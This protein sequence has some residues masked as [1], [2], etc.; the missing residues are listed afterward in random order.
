MRWI[1]SRSQLVKL[2]ISAVTDLLMIM[3]EDK[4]ERPIRGQIIQGNRPLS[5][6]SRNH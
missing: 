3:V 1:G 4:L 6:F 5:E 2:N